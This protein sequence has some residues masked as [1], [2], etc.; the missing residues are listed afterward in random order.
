MTTNTPS[1]YDILNEYFSREELKTLVFNLGQDYDQIIPDGATKPVLVRELL[2]AA[3]AQ[4]FVAEVITAG[5][6][7]IDDAPWPTHITAETPL[8]Q[9]LG[10]PETPRQPYEPE[11][12]RIPAGPF[13]MGRHPAENISS[14]ETPQFL[15]ELPTFYMGLYPVTNEQYAAFVKQTNHAPPQKQ[16]WLGRTPPRK[17]LQHPVAGV[18]WEDAQ[19]YVAWLRAETG[20]PYRL[21]TEAEWEKAARGTDGRVYPWGNEWNPEACHH[22][23]ESTAVVTAYP[24]GDSPYACRQM[25]GNV[26]EWTST[27]WGENWD[28]PQFSY[29]YQPH[30]GREQTENLTTAVFR[31]FRG[32]TYDDKLEKLSCTGRAHYAANGIAPRVGFRIALS[33]P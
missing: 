10:E 33:L 31:I 3:Q 12:V 4:N 26:G 15:L 27:L 8:K 5:Q 24:A 19:A 22:Q 21:P 13:W 29:P 2:K 6:Q 1:L 32:G 28:E 16:G 20:R 9:L 7:M 18:T 30:D 14:D 25:V 17:R 23:A 11:T